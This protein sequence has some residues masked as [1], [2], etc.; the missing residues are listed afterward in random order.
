M[1]V[2]YAV[3]AY[4][5]NILLELFHQICPSVYILMMLCQE[6]RCLLHTS[7]IL[8]L[9]KLMNIDVLYYLSP[10]A[11]FLKCSVTRYNKM[12]Q[13]MKLWSTYEHF[14]VACLS[15]F[16][17][18]YRFRYGNIWSTKLRAC[19]IACVFMW[20]NMCTFVCDSRHKVSI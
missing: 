8:I 6:Q 9:S 15:Y 5:S 14:V 1:S 12:E 16:S 19:V 13:I 4:W 20:L 2:C 18:K 17:S 10:W 11:R 3:M 7:C